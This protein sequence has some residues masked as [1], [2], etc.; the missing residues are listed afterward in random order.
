LSRPVITGVT[1]AVAVQAATRA[2]DAIA[3]RTAMRVNFI[4]SSSPRPP[5]RMT[6]SRDRSACERHSRLAVC[7]V[8][9]SGLDET[10]E[11]ALAARV[12][13]VVGGAVTTESELRELSDQVDG[14]TRAL[15]AQVYGSERR[16]ARLGADPACEFSEIAP[17]LRRVETLSEN[18]AELRSLSAALDARTRELR[19]KWLLERGR[20][21]P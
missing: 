18:L 7:R 15:Q 9:V 20:V 16:L 3:A 17:E 4:E 12:R 10:L 1:V 8:V 13:E 2:A 19:T 6:I 14:W 11:R 5:D 21:S